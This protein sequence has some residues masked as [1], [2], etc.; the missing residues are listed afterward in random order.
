MTDTRKA[1]LTLYASPDGEGP[2]G[3]RMEV[4]YDG[5]FDPESVVDNIINHFAHQLIDNA[6]RAA[7]VKEEEAKAKADRPRIVL[8]GGA[9]V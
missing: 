7:R 3:I 2:D 8:V 5:D 6:E 9:H 4:A 1:S